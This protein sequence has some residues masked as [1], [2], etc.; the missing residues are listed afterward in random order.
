MVCASPLASVPQTKIYT[1]N[2]LFCG[3]RAERKTERGGVLQ[4]HMLLAQLQDISTKQ[5]SNRIQCTFPSLKAELKVT[6]L[7]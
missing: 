5:P 6:H 4:W 1:M 7:R 2:L 3:L